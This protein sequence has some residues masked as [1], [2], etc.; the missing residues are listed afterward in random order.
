MAQELQMTLEQIEAHLKA[1]NLEQYDKPQGQPGGAAAPQQD[2]AAILK[3]ICAVYKAI[4]PILTVVVNFPL[5]PASIKNAIK[6]FM[7]V[8]NSICP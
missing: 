4:K 6:T 2:L 8:M 3:R 1:A 5:I 7:N